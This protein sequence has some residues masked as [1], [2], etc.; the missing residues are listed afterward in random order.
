M[1]TSSRTAPKPGAHGLL[2]AEELAGVELA[3]RVDGDLVDDDPERLGVEPVDDD[4]ARDERAERELD[5]AGGDVV[6]GERARLVDHEL[7]ASDGDAGGDRAFA[8]GADLV[9]EVRRGRVAAMR[10]PHAEPASVSRAA[11]S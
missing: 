10:S 3:L 6:A 5:R 1:A 4:L 7:V 8:D 9:G 2:D 11:R